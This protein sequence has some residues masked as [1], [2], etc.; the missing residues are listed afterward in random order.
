MLQ[1]VARPAYE[2]VGLAFRQAYIGAG[3]KAKDVAAEL[4]V[5]PATV[6]KWSRGLQRI[7]LEYFPEIDKLCSLPLGTVLRW[8]GYVA[9]DET[10]T[11]EDA[12]RAD[13]RLAKREQDQ[14]ID[15]HRYLVERASSGVKAAAR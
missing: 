15:F 7:D 13:K 12:I 9:D 11:P 5:D 8:A 4:D 2:R 1:F 14:L 10:M 3:L 6:S